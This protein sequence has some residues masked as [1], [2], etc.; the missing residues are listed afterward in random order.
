MTRD[1][2]IS[3]VI[4]TYNRSC[5]LARAIESALKQ[6]YPLNE[7][8]VVDDGSIDNTYNIVKRYGNRVRYYFQEN[9]GV[10][11]ARNQGVV[12][13]KSPWVAFLDSDDYW[14]LHYIEKMVSAISFFENNACLYFANCEYINNRKNYYL[15]N[16]ARFDINEDFKLITDAREL[17]MRRI[18]PIM[19]QA[20]ILLKEKF[21]EIGGF[22]LLQKTRED[23]DLFFRICFTYSVCAVNYVGA[24]ITEDAVQKDRLTIKYGSNSINYL[25][26]TERMYLSLIQ[27]YSHPKNEYVCEIRRRLVDIYI[28]LAKYWYSK[29]KICSIFYI[30][31]SIRIK[32]KYFFTRLILKAKTYMSA[33][34]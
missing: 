22:N 26:A 11:F 31:K 30:I 4:P 19:L 25:K 23:T 3:L 27:N 6:T 15:W 13:S 16:R 29:D 18:Q 9:K 10:S 7:T 12:I 34:N 14:G 5:T 33:A 8:I 17:A 1:V 28:N 24:K 32:F 21:L 20:S 2:K